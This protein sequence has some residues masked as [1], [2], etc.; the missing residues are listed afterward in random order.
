MALNTTNSIE[1][2][3]TALA[4]KC[5][6]TLKNMKALLRKAGVNEEYKTTKVLIPRA[7]NSGDD[8][9][10]IGLNGVGFWFKR[11]TSVN[12]PDPLLEILQNTGMI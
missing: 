8:V 3:S 9:L 1:K 10:F 5:E 2:T 7:V 11:N 12:M 4:P 6:A